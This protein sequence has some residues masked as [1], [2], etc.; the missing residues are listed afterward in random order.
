MKAAKPDRRV[1]ELVEA[2][3]YG[4][5]SDGGSDG[6]MVF[7]SVHSWDC[8]GVLAYNRV[9]QQQVEGKARQTFTVCYVS[10]EERRWLLEDGDR[11]AIVC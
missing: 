2:S 9:Q 6:A 5:G 7:V 1:Y 8:V 3:G 10:E 11:P 4:G